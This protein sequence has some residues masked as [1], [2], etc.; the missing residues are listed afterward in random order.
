M[1]GKKAKK[2]ARYESY[3]KEE[4]SCCT[5]GAD[6]PDWLLLLVGGFG[7][8]NAMGW[9][10]WPVF[11]SGFNAVWPVIVVVI[12]VKNLMERKNCKC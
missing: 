4:C 5:P 12:A 10:T 2:K 9:V 1:A 3:S 7:L 11:N 6:V 8:L